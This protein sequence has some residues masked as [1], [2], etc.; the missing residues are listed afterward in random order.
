MKIFK[1]IRQKFKR[2]VEES[3]P[4]ELE[5]KS[6]SQSK[7][8]RIRN[9]MAVA[10]IVV[11]AF[12]G[13]NSMSVRAATSGNVNGVIHQG[14]AAFSA[15]GSWS[16]S[17]SRSGNTVTVTVNGSLTIPNGCWEGLSLYVT[18]NKGAGDRSVQIAADGS[19]WPKTGSGSTSYSFTDANA[20]TASGRIYLGFRSNPTG[21]LWADYSIGY[22]S[23]AKKE[24]KVHYDL[25]GGSWNTAAINNPSGYKIIEDG[26]YQIQWGYNSSYYIH[27]KSGNAQALGIHM[28]QDS[29][30]ENSIWYFERYQ[31][32]PYYFIVGNNGWDLASY[33]T[34]RVDEAN[35]VN[36][37]SRNNHLWAIEEMSNGNIALKNVGTG[38]YIFSH[39]ATAGNGNSIGLWGNHD[40]TDCQWK[41]VKRY[42]GTNAYRKKL[43]GNSFYVNQ[44]T[45]V[46]PGYIFQGWAS[47]PEWDTRAKSVSVNGRTFDRYFIQP[48]GDNR[49]EVMVHTTDSRITQVSVPVWSDANG[50][51]DLQ[52]PTLG[53]GNWTRDGQDFNW[54]A[55]ITIPEE[56]SHYSMHIY[57]GINGA[58][59]E[60]VASSGLDSVWKIGEQYTFDT[61]TDGT[62]YATWRKDDTQYQQ[63]VR[64]RFENADGSFTSYQQAHQRTVKA[65]T[66]FT[67]IYPGNATY[68][69]A[70]VSYTV[71]GTKSTDVTIYRNQ[72]TATFDANGGTTASP[73]TLTRRA[74][75]PLG[76]LPT[77][78]RS[79]YTF[80]GWYTAKTGG[81]KISTSTTMPT[82]NTTYYAHWVPA[83]YTVTY[84]ANGGSGT[85]QTQSVQYG[86]A[87]TTKGAVF[88]KTGYTLSS[89]NTKADGSGTKYG[90][91]TKQTDKQSSNLTLYAQWQVNTYTYNVKYVST[92][93]VQ[94]GTGTVSGTFGSS[95]SVSPKTFTGYTS[96]AA[97]TVKFDSTTAKTITFKYTPISYKITYTLN[98][99][100]VTGNPSTYTIETATITLKNPTKTGY[101]FKGWTGSNGTTPQTTVKI[102]K[103]STGN[104]SYTANWALASATQTIRVRYQNA[105][106]TFGS[107][108]QAYQKNH[109]I[110]S[111]FTWEYPGNATYKPATVSYKV[112]GAKTTDVTIYRKEYKLKVIQR[113]NGKNLTAPNYVG[114][115][116]FYFENKLYSDNAVAV[117]TT[118]LAG[119]S[120]EIKNI[121]ANAGYSYKSATPGL[122]G[123]VSS[124][125]TVYL[126]F[127][128][129]SYTAT[130]DANGGTTPN[131]QTIK[132]K[133]GEALGTLPTTSRT[134]YTFQGWYTAKT[135]G[136]KISTTTKMPSNNVTYYAQWK[137][138]TYKV[139]Y[140]GNGSTANNPGSVAQMDDSVHTY[141][142]KKALSKNQYEKIGWDF[143]GW[144]TKADGSGTSYKDGQVVVNLASKQDA[145]VQLYAQWEP[146]TFRVVF[147]PNGGET[148]TPF[149]EKEGEQNKP[150]GEMPTTKRKGYTFVGWF[151]SKNA[152]AKKVDENTVIRN[153]L[154]T[155]Y[156]HWE[157]NSYSITYDYDG[158]T[159]VSNP[160][161]Y[162][163][164]TNTFTLKNPTRTG[165]R[166]D[167]WTGSN[168]TTPQQTVTIQ[169][170][171]TGDLSYTANWT[172][173]FYTVEYNGNGAT[174]GST[175]SSS[176]TYDKPK[177]LT[178]NG[179]TNSNH[180]FVQWNTKADGSGVAYRDQEVVEN[181]TTTNGA[182][183]TLYA[184]WEIKEVTLTFDPTGGSEVPPIIRFAGDKMGTLP[185]TERKGYTFLG[186]YTER[187]GGTKLSSSS[188]VPAQN[189]TYYAHWE[190]IDYSITYDLNGGKVS[191]NPDSYTVESNITLKNPTKTGHT[192]LGWTGTGLN[193]LTKNVT[194]PKGSTGDRHYTANWKAHTYTIR[195]N[196]NGSTSGSTAT[197]THTYGVAKN[198][199]EN[200]FHRTG[201]TF[202]GWNTKADGSGTS[203]KNA[204]SVKNLTSSDGAVVNLYARWYIN[205]YTVTFNPN[206]DA[207]S[208]TVTIFA[209]TRDE[210]LHRADGS[211]YT[212]KSGGT[213]TKY[214]LTFNKADHEKGLLS[215]TIKGLYGAL[216]GTIRKVE[217][218]KTSI[219][220]FDP[221]IAT[222]VISFD[223]NGG[224]CEIESARFTVNS[225][226]SSLPTPQREGYTFDGWFT[227]P[228]GGTRVTTS[229]PLGEEDRTVYAH[230]TAK[231]YT[232][233]YHGNNGSYNG[234]ETYEDTVQWGVDY[235]V[236]TNFFTRSGWKFRGWNTKADG[237]G[238][239]WTGKI[240]QNEAW[241]VDSDVTLYAQWSK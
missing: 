100:S 161:S 33:G 108:Q 66:T 30:N 195:Y 75:Q 233:T 126:D 139:H 116:D 3:V 9:V 10:G 239:D 231:T 15:N 19:A 107:Y 132:K 167:G 117:D 1:Q 89:W 72:Y 35:Q 201:Y 109:A 150:I 81:T 111:T 110:G 197:S 156:A 7:R 185:E 208:N 224:T 222:K 176:H 96:P 83:S 163:V 62:M 93:G 240:G 186:W 147:D 84:K 230:W 6:K 191:G 235:E 16:V 46:K 67:W 155:V 221:A 182:T 214:V 165:Y 136:T 105:D 146:S 181:L 215:V 95:K 13:V 120:Y 211:S 40:G 187:T 218:T 183:V 171:T 32:T 241:R 213:R 18:N 45:P 151:D 73:K 141:D 200:G 11:A 219:V 47:R 198:L 52:W 41:L 63:T 70:K 194:I 5:T 23:G 91:N 26:N 69:L 216:D 203:Y 50:Q 17:A 14:G 131:P 102:A 159:P 145:V 25:N 86:T 227:S 137:P 228:D 39:Y 237:T 157:L 4:N 234:K 103:G 74:Q 55:Q 210:T 44:K 88:T 153:K 206:M 122:K 36:D 199:T 209:G 192:F 118:V 129:N 24:H 58:W 76:T 220:D 196:G 51:D 20:G 12:V 115:F 57:T 225:K 94:L 217:S 170:G 124:D 123:T 135:G 140:N 144:N 188:T 112:T 28:W 56:I 2:N 238:K 48:I 152:D 92:S 106:G 80:Q 59:E 149:S 27:T 212:D 166:F 31:N 143:V 71:T 99:G 114:N 133:Y 172:P 49:F 179:F 53:R 202:A 97:Q 226:L 180:V 190:T 79:G 85:D 125:L 229:T 29:S 193:G 174:G 189:R 138:I 169:K 158:G 223:P 60:A 37:G 113:L 207:S 127:E 236:S 164:E 87:W 205:T 34:E 101:T 78:S 173:I 184:I 68:K 130:F 160:T 21:G 128:T 38:R 162:S 43:Q 134:G 121:Q 178:K 90:L 64:V 98:G 42:T 119:Q 8:R 54:G 104:K 177:Q 168:G 22:S 61:N 175:A 77:T 65:G 142:V 232:I 204:Q 148:P 82:Q 154:T